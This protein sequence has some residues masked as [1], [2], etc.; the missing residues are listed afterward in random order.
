MT[1]SW[2]LD[3]QHLTT[4]NCL[5]RI[6]RIVCFSSYAFEGCSEDWEIP[7]NTESEKRYYWGAGFAHCSYHRFVVPL[8]FGFETAISRSYVD[9]R[10]Q[11]EV[12]VSTVYQ[13]HSASV[14]HVQSLGQSLTKWLSIADFH[15]VARWYPGIECLAVGP[16][17]NTQQSRRATCESIM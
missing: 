3:I 1:M 9:E 4:S 5:I 2:Y 12:R 13:W 6:C 8:Q 7:W 10:R 16:V 14:G 11:K 15:L 17:W